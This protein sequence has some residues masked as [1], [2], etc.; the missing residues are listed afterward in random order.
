MKTLKNVLLINAMSSGATGI[1]LIGFA[2][3]IAKLFG[4]NSPLPISEVGVFLTVFA[5]FVFLEGRRPILRAGKIK[6]IIALDV[7]WTLVSLFVIGLQL[8]DLT[9]AGYLAIGAVALWVFAMAYLQY[10]GVKQITTANP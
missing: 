10:N 2:S 7:T 9:S 5:L 4:L 1:G 6:V 8:F 3:P